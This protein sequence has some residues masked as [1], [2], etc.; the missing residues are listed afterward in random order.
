LKKTSTTRNIAGQSITTRSCKK[1]KEH[2]ADS[3]PL[4]SDS[5]QNMSHVP[6]IFVDQATFACI[7]EMHKTTQAGCNNYISI[8]NH[9]TRSSTKP[10]AIL[11][12]NHEN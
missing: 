4:T 8:P 11:S 1:A 10:T 7:D 5:L 6:H 2:T 12:K 9:P 3:Y